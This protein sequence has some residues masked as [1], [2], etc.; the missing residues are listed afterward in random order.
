MRAR[1]IVARADVG[2]W[3]GVPVDGAGTPD[4][5][6]LTILGANLSTVRAHRMHPYVL[7]CSWVAN[8]PAG[9]LDVGHRPDLVPGT[10][11][12]APSCR[13]HRI[14]GVPADPPRRLAP[15]DVDPAWHDWLY[16]A[17][18]SGLTVSAVG[19]GLVPVAARVP[20]PSTSH[21]LRSTLADLVA[22]GEGRAA[23]G[24]AS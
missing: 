5:L 23:E 12:W 13:C 11:D 7:V 17:D 10:S 24:V 2:G 21:G 19:A 20:W 15:V 16:L 3:T 18:P 22:R 6:G 14:G 8:H 9:F 1:A 4:V